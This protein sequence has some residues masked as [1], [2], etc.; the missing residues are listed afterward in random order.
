M[1]RFVVI[2][3][4]CWCSSFFSFLSKKQLELH[5]AHNHAWIILLSHGLKEKEL[6]PEEGCWFPISLK[7]INL[8]DITCLSLSKAHEDYFPD[9]LVSFFERSVCKLGNVQRGATKN[10]RSLSK[11]TEI[12]LGEN[13]NRETLRQRTMSRPKEEKHAAHWMV[14]VSISRCYH[15]FMNRFVNLPPTHEGLFFEAVRN[16]FINQAC[17]YFVDPYQSSSKR[18]GRLIPRR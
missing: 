17:V 16:L 18:K 4:M 10:D 5:H 14:S 6:C 13:V 8:L 12:I 9:R 11:R 15:I 2:Q 7:G 1:D 3:V